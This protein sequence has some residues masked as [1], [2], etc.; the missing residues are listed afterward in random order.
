MKTCWA[1]GQYED[2]IAVV[3]TEADAEEIF[4]DLVIEE[5][6]FFCVSQINCGGRSM[7]ECQQEE[8]IWLTDWDYFLIPVCNLL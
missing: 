7:E 5:Q 4:M 6:Y 8:W 3:E 1:I 2:P